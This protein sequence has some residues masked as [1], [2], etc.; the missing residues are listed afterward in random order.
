MGWSFP[1][2]IIHCVILMGKIRNKLNKTFT[3]KLR[4]NLNKTLTG[5]LRI[6]INKTLTARPPTLVV[7]GCSK[8]E[9]LLLR[10]YGIEIGKREAKTTA[11]S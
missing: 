5:E 2:V 9:P 3:G 11:N 4:N 7:A 10:H 8:I 6:G 1:V